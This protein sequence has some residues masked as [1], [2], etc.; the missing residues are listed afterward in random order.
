MKLSVPKGESPVSAG[1]VPGS[2]ASGKVVR[3]DS[4]TEV[5]QTAVSALTPNQVEGRLNRNY[6]RRLLGRMRYHM[7]PKSK[8][9]LVFR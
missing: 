6:I 9:F 8:V 1:V 5:S 4:G 3:G 7:L 2:Q